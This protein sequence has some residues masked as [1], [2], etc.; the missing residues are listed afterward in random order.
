MRPIRYYI[1]LIKESELIEPEVTTQKIDKFDIA[2]LQKERR[3]IQYGDDTAGAYAHATEIDPHQI[4]LSTFEPEKPAGDAKYQYIEAVK[5]LMGSNPYAPNVYEIKL[6]KEKHT[7]AQQ[8]SYVMQKLVS[9]KDVPL[10]LLYS[11]CN[12]IIND[13]ID[14]NNNSSVNNYATR[15]YEQ[16]KHRYN[17]ISQDIISGDKDDPASDIQSLIKD[18]K[19]QLMTRQST[20]I[21]SPKSGGVGIWSKNPITNFKAECI[22]LTTDL[23]GK[24]YEGRMTSPN[25]QLNQVINII[26]KITSKGAFFWD[27]HPGNVMFRPTG[28]GY[29]LVITDPIAQ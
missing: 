18:K 26:K 29:Q 8:P 27:L 11:S 2:G 17:K 14:A 12:A 7:K 13:I 3:R 23:I 15:K 1:D 25:D 4:K 24:V 6:V 9:Y 19:N 16:L 28:A 22:D 20:R 21:S 5:P 10:L